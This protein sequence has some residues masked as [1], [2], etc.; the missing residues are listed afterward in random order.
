MIATQDSNRKEED[1]PQ[2]IVRILDEL[3][4]LEKVTKDIE[5]KVTQ[6]NIELFGVSNAPKT[7]QEHSIHPSGDDL[8]SR[9]LRPM[10]EI[11]ETVHTISVEVD[12]MH[13]ELPQEGVKTQDGK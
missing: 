9:I 4:Y 1:K 12:A 5:H 3:S 11:A 7:V 10:Q 2:R 6:F 13:R 8:L